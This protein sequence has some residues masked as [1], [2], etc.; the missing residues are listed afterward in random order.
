MIDIIGGTYYEVCHEP[1]YEGLFGSGLRGAIAISGKGFTINYHSSI[2][3]DLKEQLNYKTY[4]YEIN[5][6]VQ[7]RERSIIF[8][9]YHPLAK[10]TH[11]IY[12]KIITYYQTYML[13][14]YFTMV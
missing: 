14:I 8:D 13:K 3:E 6:N 12:Q 9:Y 4:A 10:P 11:I 5:E 2:G 1:L 7:L